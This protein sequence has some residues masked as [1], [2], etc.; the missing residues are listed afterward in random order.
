VEAEPKSLVAILGGDLALTFLGIDNLITDDYLEDSL[1]FDISG[2]N[3]KLNPRQGAFGPINGFSV[4]PTSQKKHA[5]S[6]FEN[7][8]LKAAFDGRSGSD[9]EIDLPKTT[10]DEKPSTVRK[11][12]PEIWIYD[13]KE[14][15]DKGTDLTWD[16]ITP[17]SITTWM[18]SAFGIHPE[19]CFAIASTKKIVASQDFFIK[20][21]KPPNVQL[22]ETV[23]VNVIVYNYLE[24]SGDAKV[25]LYNRDK[26]YAFVS[27]DIESQSLVTFVEKDKTARVTFTIVPNDIGKVMLYVDATLEHA[28]DE[29]EDFF[30]VDV[31]TITKFI[32]HNAPIVLTNER[33]EVTFEWDFDIPADHIKNSVICKADASNRVMQHHSVEIE[34][35]PLP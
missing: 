24:V 18:I 9:A 20:L 19:K 1:A 14:V 5:C 2:Y 30:M 29:V 6:E 25:T 23:E 16:L 26:R 33:R 4:S 7:N 12:F 22:G 32:P 27:G 11:N 35:D 28:K 10:D 3:F 8:I 15:D 31:A 34:N 17:D 13:F 21:E